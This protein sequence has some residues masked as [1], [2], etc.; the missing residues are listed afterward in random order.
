MAVK[1]VIIKYILSKKNVC[2]WLPTGFQK[3]ILTNWRW[4]LQ[5]LRQNVESNELCKHEQ[6]DQND[7]IETKQ[8]L[9]HQPSVNPDPIEPFDA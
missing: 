9:G 7:P 2:P 1:F 3:R 8:N 4:F 6:P 5:E